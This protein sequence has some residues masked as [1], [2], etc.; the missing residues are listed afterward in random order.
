M[1]V[2]RV[3]RAVVLMGLRL[4]AIQG[5]SEHFGVGDREFVG[6][7]RGEVLQFSCAGATF[8]KACE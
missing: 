1:A 7:W 3:L 4:A 5:H 8:G 6:E 2:R